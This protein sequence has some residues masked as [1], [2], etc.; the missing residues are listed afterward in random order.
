[1]SQ[2]PGNGNSNSTDSG[3]F[4]SWQSLSLPALLTAMCALVGHAPSGFVIAI[5]GVGAI[6]IYVGAIYQ[7]TEAQRKNRL[8]WAGR[9][10]VWL[11]NSAIVIGNVVYL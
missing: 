3:K 8:W 2:S 10:L 6:A 11:L 9:T 5:G 4:L 7:A 1:M